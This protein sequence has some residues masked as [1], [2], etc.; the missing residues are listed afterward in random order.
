MP[1]AIMMLNVAEL[2]HLLQ[3]SP[4][5]IRK[6]AAS[7]KLSAI[8]IQGEWMFPETEVAEFQEQRRTASQGSLF[9]VAKTGQGSGKTDFES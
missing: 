9:K 8:R 3:F 6:W 4:Q 2:A 7:G 5:T 1:R